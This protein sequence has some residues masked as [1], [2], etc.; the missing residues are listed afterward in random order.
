MTV[1]RHKKRIVLFLI[2]LV[3][4]AFAFLFK[5]TAKYTC[6][7]EYSDNRYN[8][9]YLSD[10]N[11]ARIGDKLYFNYASDNSLFK[12]G[13]YEIG[14]NS[15]R[16]IYWDGLSFEPGNNLYKMQVYNETLL[17]TDYIS[18]NNISQIVSDD[19]LLS[20]FDG[21]IYYFDLTSESIKKLRSL[22]N[23]DSDN[24]RY[25][26]V[27]DDNIFAFTDDK[28]YAVDDNSNVTAVFDK[29]SDA[30]NKTAYEKL[31]YISDD[32]ILYI[33]HNSILIEYD[34]KLQQEVFA[35]DLS[36]LNI[37]LEDFRDVFT[38][39]NKIVVTAYNDS[40]FQAY[41]VDLNIE[42]LYEKKLQPYYYINSYGN[43]LLISSISGGLDTVNI[44]TGKIENLVKAN[45]C[46][47][48][49]VDDVWI[50]Y[51]DSKGALLRTDYSGNTEEKIFE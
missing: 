24:Y 17:A 7:E 23:Y 47:T 15:S 14:E 32:K 40:V 35:R 29:L 16:R 9:S 39:D 8:N 48:Y 46:D 26:Y 43:K 41:T 19:G 25:Y 45:V 20:Q 44:N 36:D 3:V 10:G 12:N 11:L 34:I 51:V 1:K 21:D 28:I 31:C 38:C 2:I 22:D 37:K 42:L 30:V 13:L 18:E 50:Y 4:F 6:A 33:N 49:I 27:I 5:P